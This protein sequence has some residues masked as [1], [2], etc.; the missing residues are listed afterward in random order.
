MVFL[1]Q[2]LLD[3]GH[4][5]CRCAKGLERQESS[6]QRRRLRGQAQVFPFGQVQHK[7]RDTQRERKQGDR[8]KMTF[9]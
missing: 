3:C 8:K 4:G 5:I 9:F 1:L 7:Q 2:E 6:R